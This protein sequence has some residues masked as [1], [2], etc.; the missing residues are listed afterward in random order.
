MLGAVTQVVFI[1]CA[2][3]KDRRTEINDTF[4]DY[5]DFINTAMPITI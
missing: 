1:N 4:V 5:V 3:F 2:P